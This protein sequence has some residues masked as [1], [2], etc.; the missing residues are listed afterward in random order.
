MES[1][2]RSEEGALRTSYTQVAHL[3]FHPHRHTIS[4]SPHSRGVVLTPTVTVS[5]T[6]H[7]SFAKKYRRAARRPLAAAASRV[8]GWCSNQA[9]STI[10][11]LRFLLHRPRWLRTLLHS[12][13]LVHRSSGRGAATASAVCAAAR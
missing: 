10:G 3:T 4:T 9:F 2:S 12:S 8:D 5:R 6:P 11:R 1:F 7:A 13:D